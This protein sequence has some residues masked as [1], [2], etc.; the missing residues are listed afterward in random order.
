MTG[1]L[2]A[3]EEQCWGAG[4][5]TGTFTATTIHHVQMGSIQL[6]VHPSSSS[7]LLD[8]QPKHSKQRSSMHG[9]TA[10]FYQQSVVCLVLL[11]PKV[12]CHTTPFK[13]HECCSSEV[14][15][16]VLEAAS[17]TGRSPLEQ[18]ITDRWHAERLCLLEGKREG[19][20]AP[21]GRSVPRRAGGMWS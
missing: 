5:D 16:A 18:H 19:S 13:Q 10:G 7:P 14:I 21:H 4:G 17:R 15:S 8:N 9:A 1:Q 3:A 11:Q 12:A 2:Q 6:Q 20:P